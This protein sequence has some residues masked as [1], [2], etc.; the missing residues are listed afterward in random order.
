MNIY[1]DLEKY[2]KEHKI[3]PFRLKKMKLAFFQKVLSDDELLNLFPEIADLKLHTL[4]IHSTHVS[5]DESIKI[6]FKTQDGL[7]I[8][9]VILRITQGPSKRISICVSCQVG[10]AMACEFCSTGKLGLKRNLSIFE[11]CDQIQLSNQ[12]LKQI[13]DERSI[14]NVVFMGQGEPTNNFKNVTGAIDLIID[15]HRFNIAAK[16]ITVSTVGIA[17]IMAKFAEYEPQIYYA[18]SLHSARQEIRETIM[19]TAKANTVESLKAAIK[20]LD[21]V[22]MIEYLMLSGLTDTEEDVAALRSFC[23]GLKVHLNLIPYNDTEGVDFKGSSMEDI[24]AFR[25]KLLPFVKAVTIRKSLGADVWGACGNLM[26]KT[27]KKS[28]TEMEDIVN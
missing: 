9:S 1:D 7:L 16:H 28:L 19:P 10:C 5:K 12:F 3:E 18:L 11:I 4:Q 20:K 6:I 21:R 17:K 14:R 15:K 22:F 2:R 8:E 24:A 23:E 25:E 13:G 26:L 27:L